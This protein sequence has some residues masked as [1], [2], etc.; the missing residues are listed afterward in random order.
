MKRFIFI[1]ILI[2]TIFRLILS[3]KLQL[4][5]DEAYYWLWSK[6]LDLS[7]FDHPPMVAYFIRITTIFF[8]TEFF[9]RLSSLITF[10]FG[11]Y[12]MWKLVRKMFNDEEVANMSLFIFNLFPMLGASFIITPDIPLMFFW[13]LSL[14]FIWESISKNKIFYWIVSGLFVGL[15][16]L[17]KYNGIFLLVCIFIFL[18]LS[19][20]DRKLL[21]NIGPYLVLILSII[22]F[23]PVI[24]W[25]YNN[26][27]ISFKFQ[28]F[29]GI[30]NISGNFNN[31]ISYFVGQAAAMGLFLGFVCLVLTYVSIFSKSRK[32][33]FL[34]I[35]SILPIT[36]FAITSYKTL[37]EMNWPICSYPTVSVLC[38]IF[39]VEK[40]SK[41]KNI[42]LTFAATFSITLV[43]LLYLQA[44]I[45]ILPLEKFNKMW[46]L[47]DPTNWFYGWKEFAIFLDSK[48]IDKPIVSTTLQ[49]ASELQYYINKPAKIFYN[50]KQFS[51]WNNEN[52]PQEAICI[53]YES[54]V[55]TPMPNSD[56]YKKIILVDNYDAV[57]DN[58][59]IR[60][61]NIYICE[62]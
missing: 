4:H 5:P 39:F 12:I 15:T 43:F 35:F 42:F 24:L 23:L 49:L 40:K 34:G 17:S 32:K 53:N 36:V 57:R 61:Y 48:D 33:L 18:I 44:W 26:N 59:I 1:L 56:V 52:Y 6:N 11:I 22:I 14:Y 16:M 54:D 2:L 30:P 60:K 38:A 25:N 51:V 58:N 37:A 21:F 19:K 29:H 46:V 47:T 55:K 62:K 7:Y 28:F 41:L 27:W 9:V 20:E 13:I 10:V 50:E 8:N 31:I 45:R 3:A